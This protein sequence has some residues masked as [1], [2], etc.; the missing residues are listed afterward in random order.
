MGELAATT[1]LT[2]RLRRHGEIRCRLS[3]GKKRFE[4]FAGRVD[5]YLER[6]LW[7]QVLRNHY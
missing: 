3:G 2:N 4:S 6:R 1:K 5:A 7:V